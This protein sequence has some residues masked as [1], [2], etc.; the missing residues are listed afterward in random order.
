VSAD[1]GVTVPGE[2]AGLVDLLL[3]YGLAVLQQR[4]GAAPTVAGL[5]G[6][7]VQLQVA[8][9]SASG[10]P[11]RILAVPVARAPELTVTEAA[12]SCGLSARQVRRLAESGALIARKRG[13]DWLID[14]QSAEQRSRTWRE[15][16]AA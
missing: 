15:Q 2:L 1:E 8:A 9:A 14:R 13:R 4:N 6:L 11:R 12:R 16:A 10:R 5:D 3:G 7:R